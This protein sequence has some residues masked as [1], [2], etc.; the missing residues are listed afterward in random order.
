MTIKGSLSSDTQIKNI[1]QK[2]QSISS[3]KALDVATGDGV[4]IRSLMKTLKGYDSFTGIDTSQKNLNTASR[5]I[6]R[7]VTQFIKMDGRELN[8]PDNS[9]DLVS[10]SESLHHIEGPQLVLKEIHRVLQ[11]GGKFVFQESISDRNQ[12]KSRLSDALIH[13]FISKVDVLRGLYHRGFFKQQEILVMVRESGFK[14]VDVF[15]SQISLKCTLCKYL[16][17]CND[18]MSK[19]MINKGLREVSRSLKY[20]KEHSQY[21]DFRKEASLLRKTIRQNG[22]SPASFVFI[23]AEK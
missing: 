6:K 4:F 22:Y 5:R 8:F 12:E 19:K 3:K 20:I 21:L 18:S 1:L 16:D 17:N 10:I 23:A 15:I 2:L 7:S 9:F 13:E 14:N 11:H